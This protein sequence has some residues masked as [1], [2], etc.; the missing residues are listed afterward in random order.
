MKIAVIDGQG[1]GIG[2]L[3]IEKLRKELGQEI[4]II[5]LGT[6]AVATSVMLKAGANDG[7]SGENA[8]IW[9]AARVDLIAGSVAIIAANSYCGELTTRMA[10]AI[11]SSPA[12]KILIPMNRCGIELSCSQD[13]PLPIQVDQLV[14]RVK[15]H[16]LNSQNIKQEWKGGLP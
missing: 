6:N 9:S 1:G 5:G 14:A 8:V 3:I 16:C 10:E 7:A 2:R 11:T 4:Y 15:N 13:E 12:T